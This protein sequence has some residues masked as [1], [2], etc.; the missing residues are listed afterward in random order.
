[1]AKGDWVW[2]DGTHDFMHKDDKYYLYHDHGGGDLHW[3]VTQPDGTVFCGQD[4]CESE[5][6]RPEQVPKMLTTKQGGSKMQFQIGDK[7]VLANG[8]GPV[9]YQ[10][11]IAEV[12]ATRPAG[13]G[14]QFGVQFPSRRTTPLFVGR[15][16]LRAV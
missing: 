4:H 3:A 10:G 12:V 16:K 5:A 13:R 6:L 7:V 9:R 1:M 8:Q 11:R 2:A 14:V 15:A